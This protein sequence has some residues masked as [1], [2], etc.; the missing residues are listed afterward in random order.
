MLFI[1]KI[2]QKEQS[3]ALVEKVNKFKKGNT[4]IQY[5]EKPWKEE[6]LEKHSIKERTTSITS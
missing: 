5:L 2:I 1:N 3:P 4:M 6:E